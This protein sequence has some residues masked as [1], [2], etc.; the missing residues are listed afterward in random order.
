MQKRKLLPNVLQY[1][2]SPIPL[3]ILLALGCSPV[4]THADT[5]T[6]DGASVESVSFDAAAKTF[7]VQMAT[8]DA[9]QYK[10]DAMLG[11]KIDLL[12]LDEFA[13]VDGTTTETVIEFARDVVQTFQFTNS[14]MLTSDVTFRYEEL[15]TTEGIVVGGGSGGGG[16][17]V[18]E[19]SSVALLASGVLGLIGVGRKK[20]RRS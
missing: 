5:L 7:S 20:H 10:T 18:P 4:A 17:T 8:T 15:K 6:L 12:T 3:L 9:L 14:D 16:N 2:P 19:P 13:T 1:F 11:T